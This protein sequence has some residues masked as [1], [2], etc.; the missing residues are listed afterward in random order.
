MRWEYKRVDVEIG[1]VSEDAFEDRLNALGDEGWELTSA[2]DH[3]RH[4][5]SQHVHLVFKRPIPDAREIGAR[6]GSTAQAPRR[7]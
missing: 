4:G 6:S 3:Q 1:Q 5:F 2:I 7:S